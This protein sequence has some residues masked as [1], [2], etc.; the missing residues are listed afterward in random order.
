MGK[1]EHLC[2]IGLNES[3]LLKWQKTLK[4]CEVKNKDPI[5]EPN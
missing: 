1:I 2:V 4:K 5:D 3:E